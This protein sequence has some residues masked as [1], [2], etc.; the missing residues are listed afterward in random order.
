MHKLKAFTTSVILATTPIT[1]VYPQAISPYTPFQMQRVSDNEKR[2]EKDYILSYDDMLRLLDEI[3]SGELENRCTS[4]ELERLKHF[5]AF[6]AKEGVLPDGSEESM[7]LDGDI[8]DLLD[9]EDNIY[10]DAVSFAAPGEYQYLIIPAL[11]NGHGEIVLCKGWLRKQWD[12]VKKFVK[13]HKKEL[14]IGAVVVVAAAVVVV[15]VVAASSAAAGAAAAS[16]A[17]AAGAAGAA[18]GSSNSNQKSDENDQQA[19]ISVPADIPPG[20][21][22][23][24]EAPIL[25]STIDDQISSFKENIVQNQFFQPTNPGDQQGLSWQENGRALG[26]LFAHDSYNSLQN[27]LPHHSRLAQEAQEINLKYSFPVPGWD[28]G[29]VIGHSEI[30]RK[31][32]TDYS[33]LYSD[34]SQEVDFNTLSHQVRGE[35]AL[36]LGYY[37]QAVQDLGKAIE[38]NP[39]NPR[40]YLERGIAHFSL[41][42]YDRSLEDYQQFASQAQKTNPLSVSEFSLG[43]A[44]GL[45]NGVYESGKGFFLF[46]ADFVKHPIQTSGQILDS[47]TALVNLVRNDEWGI[48]AETLSPEIHQLVTQWD[49]LSSEEKGELA[50]YALGKHGTDIL[51]PTALA[52]IASKSVKS[53]QELAAIRKNLQIAQ[54]TLILETAAEM[55]NAAKIAEVIETG[56]KTLFF[57]EE[58][59]VSPNEMGQLKQLGKLETTLVNKYEHLSPSMQESFALHKKAQDFLEPYVKQPMPES[60]VREL[61]HTTGIQTFPRPKG[62]PE[63]YI[64]SVSDKGVGMKYIDPKNNHSYVR[65]M[66]GK[67]HSSLPHQ[68]KPY[69]NQ[70]IHGKSVDKNGSTVPNDAPEAHIPLEDFVY[71]AD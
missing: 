66:P 38:T 7:S 41:G 20:T 39:A 8:E 1:L 69:A 11:L 68:Q 27:Q 16:A 45:P 46:M 52:K 57:A 2:T 40:P 10:K 43:V 70:R 15:A 64:V 34:P 19:P 30:D 24:H 63:N 5:V 44:K 9:G 29:A 13:K 12:H 59:G 51:T 6:L 33:Y 23:A 48:V 35:R 60:Q 67:P 3:E 22:A 42:Q 32:S 47:V 53:A 65:I 37:S 36:S 4:E 56:Q 49:A 58:L 28:Q 25:K 62:I 71:R 55:G 14:I 61:I 21:A 26:S 17:G 54:E 50:G 18:V 31:F